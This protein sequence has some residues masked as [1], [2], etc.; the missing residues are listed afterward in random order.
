MGEI[1]SPGKPGPPG[2][3]GLPGKQVLFSKNIKK[4][5]APIKH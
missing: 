5:S 1:G 2:P 3:P 4:Q